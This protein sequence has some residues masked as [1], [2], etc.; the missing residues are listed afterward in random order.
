MGLFAPWFLA[1]LVAV[2]VPVYVHLLRR[3]AT[4]PRPFSSL[5]FF[6]RRT[7]SSIKHRRL[8]YLLLFSLRTLLLLLL[9]LAFANPFINRTAA[10]MSSEKLL[11]LVIDNSFSMRAG[12]RLAD[13]RAQALSVLSSRSPANHAQVMALGSHIQILTEPSQD[14]GALRNAI[15]NVQPGDSR[16]NYGELARGIRSLADTVHTPIELHFFSD[17]QKSGMPA[18]F[19]ELVLPAN[20]SIVL[21]PVAKDPAPNWTVESVNAP[22]QVWDPKK[23]RVQV[24]VAGF[25]TPAATRT[26]SLIVNG[27]TS[28]TKNVDVPANGRATAE[29]QSLDVPYGFT[30]CEVRIDS[31]DSFPADDVSLFAVERS[32]PRRAIFVSDAGDSRSP[33][34]FRAAL[35]AAGESAF[36]LD[37]VSTGQAA[38]QQLSTYAFVVLSDLI[39]VPAPFE[40][41]LVRYVQAGGSVWILEGASAAHSTRV[42]VFGGNILE[43]RN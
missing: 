23:A 15:E 8:H 22:G 38:V 41:A 20:V 34:Y 17:M 32:D 1:G 11:L 9:I 43:S 18:S 21:H 26:V 16:A 3:H 37:V 39:S 24:V 35:A 27:K 10:N 12:T 19:S 5:M 13:A 4:V 6:E 2:A 40:A 33:L 7:Q 14:A 31:A 36:N 29:F 28:A 30:R 42:P 25:G